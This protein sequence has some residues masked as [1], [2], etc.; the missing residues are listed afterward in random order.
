MT[1]IPQTVRDAFGQLSNDAK[2]TLNG[3]NL[4]PPVFEEKPPARVEDNCIPHDKEGNAIMFNSNCQDNIK[5]CLNLYKQTYDANETIID[6]LLDQEKCRYNKKPSCLQ[7]FGQLKSSMDPK[8]VCAPNSLC[9]YELSISNGVFSANC[10]R[11]TCNG[12]AT[13][14]QISS[15]N[16]QFSALMKEILQCKVLIFGNPSGS[17]CMIAHRS[18]TEERPDCHARAKDC[19]D[20]E[21]KGCE[22]RNDVKNTQYQPPM[23]F[24]SNA[25]RPSRTLSREGDVPQNVNCPKLPAACTDVLNKKA[26]QPENLFQNVNP[27]DFATPLE[28]LNSETESIVNTGIELSMEI[29]FSPGLR[30]LADMR[31]VSRNFRDMVGQTSNR[32]LYLEENNNKTVEVETEANYHHRMLQSSYISQVQNT[33]IDS[34]LDST[35]AID[36][37]TPTS[38]PTSSTVA[39]LVGQVLQTVNAKFISLS[40][41]LILSMLLL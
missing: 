17:P 39:N 13:A 19:G 4:G 22:V 1:N 34:K 29:L 2:N 40:I 7:I 11:G 26:P 23:N 8:N 14:E 37:A 30:R 32:L 24:S 27:I 10:K 31:G 20:E 33:S 35:I 9:A 6:D 28:Y 38:V 15:I 16:T 18:Y 36:G 25:R 41:S 12:Q 5:T 3:L 21:L